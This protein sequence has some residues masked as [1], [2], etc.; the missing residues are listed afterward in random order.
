[1]LGFAPALIEVG[2]GIFGLI[3]GGASV[4]ASMSNCVVESFASC[5]VSEPSDHRRIRAFDWSSALL[6]GERRHRTV[7]MAVLYAEKC[8]EAVVLEW[9]SVV[10]GW[11]VL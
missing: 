4:L 1:V 7:D 3:C 11:K 5:R 9:W 10:G 8:S 6:E 2:V